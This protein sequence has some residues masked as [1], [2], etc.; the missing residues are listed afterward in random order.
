MA[1]VDT[2]LS[3][4][5]VDFGLVR[6]NREKGDHSEIPRDVDFVVDA[7]TEEKA[8]LM[9]NF[10]TDNHYG[11]PSYEKVALDGGKTL[12]RVLIVINT[13][14]TENVICSLNGLFV[15]LAELFDLEYNGW[16][17]TLQDDF[18]L[19]Y[20]ASQSKQQ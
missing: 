20:L 4:S 2:L 9:C 18:H 6:R 1:F 10:V 3:T 13:P 5:E 16:G 11:R 15:C 14:A 19:E 8:E 12:W 17:C 7:P